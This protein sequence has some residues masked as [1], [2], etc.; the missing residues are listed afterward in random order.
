MFTQPKD[1][2]NKTKP[3]CKK[4]CSYCQKRNHSFSLCFKKH[5]GNNDK[6]EV[7]ARSKSPQKY[8]VLYFRSNSNDRTKRNDD[9]S[10]DYYNR[11]RSQNRSQNNY[12]TGITPHR[13]DI[14]LHHKIELIMTEALLFT[15]IHVPDGITINETL[16]SI[17]LLFDQTDHLT[18]VILV[19]ETDHVLIPKTMI[20]QNIILHLDLLQDQEFLDILDFAL[21]L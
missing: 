7:Y 13:T 4:Y 3:A 14:V 6:R 16:D 15:I 21:S 5:R 11:Q 9:R 20:L 17:V 19:I 12:Y 2:N 10:N 1:P 18:D 8:F